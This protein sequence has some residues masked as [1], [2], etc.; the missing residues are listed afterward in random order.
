MHFVQELNR[1]YNIP[2]FYSVIY[3]NSL[4]QNSHSVT[5]DILVAIQ[6]LFSSLNFN[7]EM[8][9]LTAGRCH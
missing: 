7:Q 2:I 3:D 5:T 9:F 1:K 6:Q 8:Q 4:I